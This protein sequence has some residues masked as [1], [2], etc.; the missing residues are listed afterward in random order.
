[1]KLN[2]PKLR[3]FEWKVGYSS[4][5]CDLIS[6]FY[7]PAM[8]AS[9]RYDRA[10]GYFSSSALALIS[11]GIQNLYLQNGKIRL[12]ASPAMTLKDREAI[13]QGYSQ[14]DRIVEMRLLE[15][16]DPNRLS[17]DERHRL[18]LL[19]GMIADGLLDVRIAVKEDEDGYINLYHE[20]IGVFVDK[21]DD[22]ITFI[23]SP[24]ESWNGWV[25]NA[26]SFALHKS[27]DFSSEN[28]IWERTL[29]E[30]TWEGQRERVA[31]RDFPNALRKALFDLFPPKDPSSLEDRAKY[32]KTLKRSEKLIALPNWLDEGLGLRNYQKN[33]VNAWLEGN[34]RGIYAMATGTGK[35]ITALAAAAQLSN[36]YIKRKQ[37]LLILTIVPSKDLVKQWYDNASQFH[38]CPI[39]CH[40]GVSHYWPK[41]LQAVL[42][43]LNYSDEAAIEMIIATAGTMVTSRFQNAINS[44][45]GTML[46]IG[47]EMHSL[48]TRRRIDS[49]PN[50]KYRLGLSA[51]PKRHG[52]EEGT[53]ELI[54]YFGKIKC[55]I[56]LR[57]AIEQKALVPYVY[58]PI[59]VPMNDEEIRAYRELSAKIAAVL[60]SSADY[61]HFILRAG[62]LLRDRT[63]LLGHVQAKMTK[64]ESIITNLLNPSH[65]LIYVAEDTHPLYQT[66]Q[67]NLVIDLLGNKLGLK[68]NTYTSETSTDE[69]II[70]QRML[71]EGNLDALVAMRCLDEGIDI[72]EA[73]RGIVLASTQNPRQFIQRRGRILRRDDKGGKTHAELF[74]LLVVPSDVPSREDPAF[75]SE[76]R[77][78][79]REVTRALELASAA[80]NCK[81]AP[82]DALVD[83][84]RR[85]ELFDLIAD[86]LE[87][88]DWD[89]Q[90]GG[91]N[92]YRG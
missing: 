51:T 48:G 10:V 62:K 63:R 11:K 20:K 90:R 85:Y 33:A 42:D 58:E 92:A 25:G 17:Q 49:L 29:F 56:N 37:S 23:G 5:Q 41:E 19:T 80:N 55:K 1:M 13:R 67:M 8:I 65:S 6:A 4:D 9:K 30:S 24:N 3:D 12:I 82:P 54:E 77:L 81:M 91:G 75:L 88:I 46:L 89:D 57:Q 32:N 16:L 15:Y 47:D 73:K 26:E 38:L 2:P 86:Y 68:V 14:R 36:A 21:T 64:L 61:D 52:D 34:G 74:D 45:K 60:A 87:P 50:A 28:A 18:Q 79:G 40:S 78:V 35:T 70:F 83:V 59:L 66:R 69:R 72:P 76:R 53:E 27:W 71:R 84:L 44:Y 22:Y 39:C 43:G 7:E 31:V